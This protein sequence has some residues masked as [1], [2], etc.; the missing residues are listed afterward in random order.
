MSEIAVDIKLRIQK[1]LDSVN[2]F[3]SHM[4]R[5]ISSAVS[6]VS[7]SLSGLNA[8]FS[9]LFGTTAIKQI[10]NVTTAFIGL[11]NVM[12]TFSDSSE[13]AGDQ[14][15]Y[16]INQAKRLGFNV[17]EV[18]EGYKKFYA[19]GRIAGFET[20]KLQEIFSSLSE[21]A[22]VVGMDSHQLEG[23]MR[24]LQQM[25]SKGKVQAEELRGQLGE[26]LPGAFEIAAQAMGLTTKQLDK[27]LST[28]Q[29]TA[30]MLFENFPAALR[31]NYGS[32]L[33]SALRAPQREMERL[34]T[35]INLL[36][37]DLG[38]G[39]EALGYSILNSTRGLFNGFGQETNDAMN[40][41]LVEAADLIASLPVLLK[42]SF[43][44]V[45]AYL[46]PWATM[47][48][49]FISWPFIKLNELLPSSGSPEI[50][51]F[52]TW[53]L[54]TITNTMV[55]IGNAVLDL[56]LNLTTIFEITTRQLSSFIESSVLYYEQIT[57]E[58]AL[59][60]EKVSLSVSIAVS[61]MKEF[62]APVF[63]YLIDALVEINSAIESTLSAASYAADIGGFSDMA[64]GLEDMSKAAGESSESLE[65]MRLDTDDLTAETLKYTDRL[66]EVSVELSGIEQSFDQAFKDIDSAALADISDI[67]ENH[68]LTL[69]KRN[70]L[71]QQRIADS[72]IEIEHQEQLRSM[73]EM[74]KA[75]SGEKGRKSKGPVQEENVIG[76]MT[77]QLKKYYDLQKEI[78]NEIDLLKNPFDKTY[79]S[80]DDIKRMENS[81]IDLNTARKT[82]KI[83]Q[84]DYNVEIARTINQTKELIELKEAESINELAREYDEVAAAA[85]EYAEVQ[86]DLNVLLVAGKIDLDTYNEGLYESERALMKLEAQSGKMAEGD[87]FFK[88][89]NDGLFEFSHNSKTVFEEMSELTTRSFNSMTDELTEFVT[90]GKADF[91]GL[92]DS[93]VKDL[94][95]IAIQKS[96]TEPLAN[97]MFGGNSGGGMGGMLGNL[98]GGFGGGSQ[99]SML[100]AQTGFSG[101]ATGILSGAEFL[102]WAKGGAFLNGSQIKAFANGGIIGSPT[103][104]PM[105]NGAGLM[106]ESG[107]EAVMP[108]KRDSSGKLGVVSS[109]KEQSITIHINVS[110][111]N[112]NPEAIRR[113]AGQVAQAAGNATQRAMR[114]NG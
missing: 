76:E 28:G 11:N 46:G 77:K 63:N 94:T 43:D 6:A 23:A 19:A 84:E 81:I 1:A 67:L 89:L 3:T 27:M 73:A 100:S 104:F 53:L 5:G 12:L 113:S 26:H 62:F 61:K 42:N 112:G 93:I 58:T 96:I 79:D 49:D 54:S 75:L 10:G 21:T 78:S 20:E 80:A 39:F 35:D 16:I 91:R 33:T 74:D 92:V 52:W 101:G 102:S 40:D 29:I 51:G 44:I 9:A 2:R 66:S 55:K 59:I 18:A 90:T 86:H 45:L 36:I 98:L 85:Y 106:G 56:P 111:T 114:R 47:V 105:A 34:K 15:D 70:K 30:K 60:F 88:G 8:I 82:N 64:D 95:R 7:K 37:H 108:L 87:Q 24:A 110:G 17:T 57:T 107:P 22:A 97:A 32:Q 83:S 14:M 48:W 103:L 50:M 69:E 65:K 71:V 4:Q 13:E 41:A 72:K 109:G 38:P 99:S 31:E 25:M 68:N